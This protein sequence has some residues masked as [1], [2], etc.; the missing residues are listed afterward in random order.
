VP[1]IRGLRLCC[2][3]TTVGVSFLIWCVLELVCGSVGVVSGLP[4]E[5]S[6]QVLRQTQNYSVSALTDQVC[7]RLMLTKSLL[8]STEGS[9]SFVTAVGCWQRIILRRKLKADLLIQLVTWLR[10]NICNA[11]YQFTRS[12]RV[13]WKRMRAS[14]TQFSNEKA[15]VCGFE[16]R[17]SYMWEPR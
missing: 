15:L 9:Y 13:W 7:F 17:L 6:L 11:E 4:A 8:T 14:G 1:I 10:N 2:W 12:H 3:T 5:A 16:L